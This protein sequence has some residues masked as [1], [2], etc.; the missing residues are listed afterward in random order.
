MSPDNPTH[1]G[2][3]RLI[4]TPR[5]VHE[6]FE[7]GHRPEPRI[8][9][10]AIFWLFIILC[11]LASAMAIPHFLMTAPTLTA[12]PSLAILMAAVMVVGYIAAMWLVIGHLRIYSGTPARLTFL[13]IWWG[14]SVVVVF[15]PLTAG[16]TASELA[17]KLGWDQ[18]EAS[19]GGAWA[20]EILKALGVWMLLWLGRSWWNRPWHGLVAGTFVGLGMEVIEN[21]F[22]AL[23]YAV[24]NPVSDV[25]G[26]IDVFLMRC[27]FGAGIHI[28]CTGLVGFGI[29]QA[30]FAGTRRGVGWRLAQVFGWGAFAFA[31]H[32][33]WN[34]DWPAESATLIGMCVWGGGLTV[35]IALL[36]RWH[37]GLRSAFEADREPAVTIYQR[38]R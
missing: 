19:F 4:H 18:L 9:H 15:S 8:F 28:V 36:V 37:L 31:V 23:D 3:W 2:R 30:L 17:L 32:F 7:A 29:G 12:V 14:G 10:D 11:A 34:A 1:I 20:E 6:S 16:E 33:L 5:R 21:A 22:Y 35:Y 38:V 13:A 24:Y 26:V 27:T 25:Q